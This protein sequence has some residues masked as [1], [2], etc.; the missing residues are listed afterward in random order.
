VSTELRPIEP[1][2]DAAVA[3]I[4]REVMTEHGASGPG[5]AIHDPE[6]GGMS[7]AYASS[8]AGY[9]VVEQDGVMLGGGGF[10]P[11]AGSP[12]PLTCE[13]KKMYF[14]PT[15]RGGGHG[16]ALLVRLLELARAAGF[17]RC[18]LETLETMGRARRLYESLGFARLCGPEGGTGHFGCDARYA[19]DLTLGADVTPVVLAAGASSRMGAPKAALTFEPRDPV[20]GRTTTALGLVLEA[21]SAALLAEPIVV[22]GAHAA[23]ARSAAGDR[24]AR[25]VDNPRWA[26]GRATSI[27][28]GLDAVRTD[29]ALVWPVDVPLPGAKVVRTLLTARAADPGKLAWVPSFADRRG[30]PL[31]I[32]RAAFPRFTALAPDA[33]AR[34]VVRALAA[35]GALAHVAV[36]D[37]SV[38]LDMNTPSEHAA[39]VERW[40]AGRR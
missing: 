18:Y 35:E 17:R 22:T 9:L 19:L 16:R 2:D 6:V 40:R 12:E 13:L 24:P 29:A 38:L 5:F 26:D 20:R 39:L 8:R 33:S 21:C 28:A 23:I 15:L 25:L 10:A 7:A 31:L 1:R 37:E 32:A 36:D 11:L 14:R 27:R 3:A 30:H 34:D 4:V